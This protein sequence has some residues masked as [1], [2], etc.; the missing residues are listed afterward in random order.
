[1]IDDIKSYFRNNPLALTLVSMLVSI[2]CYRMLFTW[3]VSVGFTVSLLIHE[4]GHYVAAKRQKIDVTV[5]VFIPFLG[6]LISFKENPYNAEQEAYIGIAGPIAGT[7][8]A[9]ASYGLFLLTGYEPLLMIAMLGVILNLFNLIPLS[10]MDG[11]RTVTVITPWLWLVGAAMMIGAMFWFKSVIILLIGYFGF[12]Q[13]RTVLFGSAYKTG[14][15]SAYYKSSVK[16]KILYSSV[17]LGLIGVLMYLIVLCASN[18]AM[19]HLAR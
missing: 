13:I 19:Q 10:P 7:L 5:P 3:V 11:G 4:M 8:A 18:P 15:L 1:M 17:Y 14:G 12:Q 16:T 6:A 2:I 9:F